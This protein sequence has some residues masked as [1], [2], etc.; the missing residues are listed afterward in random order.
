MLDSVCI[1]KWS[2][3]NVPKGRREI[4]RKRGVEDMWGSRGRVRSLTLPCL[5]HP[6]GIMPQAVRNAALVMEQRVGHR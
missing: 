4:M 1:W 5:Q 6:S 3:Q 2:Y